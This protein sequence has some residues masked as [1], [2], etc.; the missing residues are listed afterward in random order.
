MFYVSNKLGGETSAPD[1]Q[2]I[3]LGV[4]TLALT[5]TGPGT[6]GNLLS[7]FIYKLRRVRPDSQECCESR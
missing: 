2:K 7:V 3:L 5:F 1:P 4:R 6:L